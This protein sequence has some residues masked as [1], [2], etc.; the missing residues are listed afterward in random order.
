MPSPIAHTA[1]AYF[2]WRTG[3]R[4]LP[5][6]G[7]TAAALFQFSIFAFL[8][9]LPDLDSVPG[10]IFSDLG[11]YHNNLFHSL[12]AGLLTATMVGAVARG[13]GSASFFRWFQLGLL[14]FWAHLLMDFFTVSRG[15]MLFW[16]L[17]DQRFVSPVKLLTGLH[18]SLGV[19]SFQHLYTFCS[20]GIFVLGIFL[21]V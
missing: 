11:R 10:L 2:F 3:Q 17:T 14:C 4:S 7:S 13:V 19:W 12:A 21:L 8:S 5:K 9:L 18:W 6:P 15:V 16:P 20:E 1:A